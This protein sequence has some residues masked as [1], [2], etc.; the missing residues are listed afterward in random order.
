MS[1]TA[2]ETRSSSPIS[3]A[4]PFGALLDGLEVVHALRDEALARLS[5]KGIEFAVV[6]PA[7]V[8]WASVR[9]ECLQPETLAEDAV[10]EVGLNVEKLAI[11]LSRLQP[12][13]LAEPVVRLEVVPGKVTMR[14]GRLELVAETVEGETWTKRPGVPAAALT[15]R[16]SV[17]AKRFGDA[18]RMLS[19]VSDHFTVRAWADRLEVSA[20]GDR[21]RGSCSWPASEI[22]DYLGDDTARSHFPIDYSLALLRE[23]AKRPHAWL[24]F[25]VGHDYPISLLWT[26]ADGNG[27]VEALIAPR[28]TED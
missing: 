3:I 16:G 14:V 7:H 23:A 17:G 18:V 10:L 4:F 27:E 25:G 11:W 5:R 26:I 21:D 13:S 28:I 19:E 6:D 8:A 20:Q 12:L 24:R 22:Q 15:G 9:V 2:A 1:A